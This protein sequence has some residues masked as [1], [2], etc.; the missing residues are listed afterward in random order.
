MQSELS[1]I[2]ALINYNFFLNVAS[3]FATTPCGG[4]HMYQSPTRA[5]TALAPF[6]EAGYAPGMPC[7]L[8]VLH[9][10]IMPP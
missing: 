4:A 3:A 2:V 10:R 1:G 9:T 6:L 8:R 5:R 7:E